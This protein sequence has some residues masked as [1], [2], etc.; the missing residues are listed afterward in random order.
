MELLVEM[1]EFLD[2]RMA[3]GRDLGVSA[4]VSV[5]AFP[6]LRDHPV[7]LCRW[8]RC[9]TF[10]SSS[11]SWVCSSLLFFQSINRTGDGRGG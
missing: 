8:V 1:L 2:M 7:S 3:G 6:K 10:I 9:D 5:S 4:S 11:A